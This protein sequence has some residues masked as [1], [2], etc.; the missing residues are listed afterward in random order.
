MMGQ[1]ASFATNPLCED[2]GDQK[3]GSVEAITVAAAMAGRKPARIMRAQIVGP[4]AAHMPAR[5][6]IAIETTP[7]TI[8]Q[9]GR[10]RMP[11]LLRGFVRSETR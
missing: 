7:V 8:M 2:P 4:I 1:S 3:E 5:D 9:Q 11:S 10:R 6:E